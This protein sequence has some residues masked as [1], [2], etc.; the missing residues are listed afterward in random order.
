M[1]R[2]TQNPGSPTGEPEYLT[3]GF[4]RRPHGVTGEI[5]MDL[6]TDF[7][8]RL[9]EGR[10]V[11]LGDAHEAATLSGSRRHAGGML[12]RFKGVETPEAVGRFRN[13]W[14]YVLRADEPAGPDVQLYQHELIGMA[15]LDEEARP[16]GQIT[17]IIE[18]GAN[19]VYV[20]KAD[21]R[22]DLLLPAISSVILRID[23][24]ART[25]RVHVLEGLRDSSEGADAD[26]SE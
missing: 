25:M 13:T 23:R 12:V 5:V 14:V 20:V 4:L 11:F 15:V 10:H 6:H 3:V 9:R 24:I 26:S 7:P 1:A 19:D 18:T 2:K 21:G 8:D 16:L 17:E 22:P